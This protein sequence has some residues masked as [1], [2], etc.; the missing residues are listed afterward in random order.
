MSKADVFAI[1]TGRYA[2][3]ADLTVRCVVTAANSI[4]PITKDLNIADAYGGGRR[5]CVRLD[6]HRLVADFEF[7]NDTLSSIGVS[8]IR[9]ESL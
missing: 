5:L 6:S 8:Y 4:V 9:S 1:L 2:D 7:Q 3:R